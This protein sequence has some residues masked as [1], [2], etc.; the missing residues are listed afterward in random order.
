MNNAIREH[1]SLEQQNQI[2]KNK[3]EIELK[4]SEMQNKY[5]SEMKELDYKKRVHALKKELADLEAKEST[6]PKKT[7]GSS[8][9][10]LFREKERIDKEVAKRKAAIENG[11]SSTEE[12]K[13]SMKLLDGWREEEYERIEK[14]YRRE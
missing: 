10:E 1:E 2:Y 3:Q 6:Q 7:R 5:E 9:T 14:Q 4:E 12:K 11:K 13:T 8:T